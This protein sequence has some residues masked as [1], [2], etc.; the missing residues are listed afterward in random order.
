M[1]GNYERTMLRLNLLKYPL[2]LLSTISLNPCFLGI[3]QRFIEHGIAPPWLSSRY[4]CVDFW[5]SAFNSPEFAG[6]RPIDYATK[7][8]GIVRVLHDF[9][10]PE[11]KTD[12]SILELG[13]NAGANL[14][15]L[16][17]LGYSTLG[18]IEL[19]SAALEQMQ[20]SFA[21]STHWHI[22]QGSFEV[23]LP[24]LADKSFD[25]VFTMAVAMHI[26]P[27]IN[28]IFKEVAR[29]ARMYILTLEEERN[30][31]SIQFPRNYQRVF[32][33]LGWH[34]IKYSQISNAACPD[35]SQYSKSTMR[36]FKEADE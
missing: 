21:E 10:Q 26:H 11:V 5:K 34:Q 18:G 25:V 19:N 28:Y 17:L 33:K 8:G 7:P 24:I 1:F 35:V 15:Y 30:A 27:S 32:G 31:S 16:S 36:L 12:C 3:Y 9:W 23:I 20:Q 2:N 22:Y 6:N 13:C 29:I 4:G 14:H